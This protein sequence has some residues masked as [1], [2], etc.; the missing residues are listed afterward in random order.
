MFV[1]KLLNAEQ[2]NNWKAQLNVFSLYMLTNSLYCFSL[3]QDLKMMQENSEHSGNQFFHRW[4][5]IFFGRR[6]VMKFKQNG[7]LYCTSCGSSKTLQFALGFYRLPYYEVIPRICNSLK[8]WS[9]FK[10][11]LSSISKSFVSH[12]FFSTVFSHYANN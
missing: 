9:H 4:N 5:D 11:R 2:C 8:T 7:T 12:L 3:H 10:V 6:D 1:V